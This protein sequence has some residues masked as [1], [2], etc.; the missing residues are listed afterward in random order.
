MTV[1]RGTLTV[2]LS[3]SFSASLFGQTVTSSVLGTVVDPAGATVAGAEVQVANQS[4]GTASRATTDTAGLFRVVNILPGTYSVSVQ[5]KGF[6]NLTVRDVVV[7]Q[8]DAHDLGR[9][10]LS[11]GEVTESVSVTAQVAA[12]ETA[13]SE[14]ASLL[15]HSQLNIDAI[16][17]RDLMSYMKLLPGVVDTT[18]SRDISGGSIMGG[19]TFSGTGGARDSSVSRWTA[20]PT[21]IPAAAVALPILSR[22]STPSAR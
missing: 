7:D 6:K 5:V 2:F 16:K 1:V 4:T 22:T 11:L 21:W 14:R 18:T 15:D 9:L 8:S 19:L 17:G 3:L 13:S 20:Q 12:V 10:Q